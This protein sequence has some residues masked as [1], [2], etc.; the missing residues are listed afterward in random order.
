MHPKIISNQN[1]FDELIIKLK[2]EDCL[3]I[4]TEFDRRTTYFA[5]LSLIQ[6]KS[7][8]GIYIIDVLELKDFNSF[9]DILSDNSILK[10]IHA[11]EQD[12]EIFYNLFKIIPVNFFDTQIA[13]SFCGLK[14]RIGYGELCNIICNVNID[15][16]LQNTNW[17]KRPLSDSMKEYVSLDVM[18]LKAIYDCLNTKLQN[19]G[20]LNEY[21]NN[22]LKIFTEEKFK[23]NSENEWKKINIPSTFSILEIEIIKSIAF[24]RNELAIK[25][26]VPKKYIATNNDIL[27][28]AK[29]KPATIK[30]LKNIHL[31][32]KSF[33][34]DKL[35][36]KIINII[37][38]SAIEG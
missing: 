11:P 14:K 33:Y 2:K 26:N 10:I 30:D 18:Y 32:S 6:I 21:F 36:N 27:N 8:L 16:N 23:I 12:F 5:K 13:A 31:E 9:K 4:D 35:A 15:K 34:K 29:A 17:M 1:D 24:V 7:N 25:A 38:G 22:I 37:I 19:N 3:S 20:K 28:I